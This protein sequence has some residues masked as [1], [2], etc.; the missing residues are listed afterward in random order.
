MSCY[1]LLQIQKM[2]TASFCSGFT[3]DYLQL[4]K[5]NFYRFHSPPKKN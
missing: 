3:I 5:L 1:N 2:P 4:K